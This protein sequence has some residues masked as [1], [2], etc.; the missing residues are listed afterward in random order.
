MLA[1]PSAERVPRHTSDAA[2]RAIQAQ[3]ARNIAY[4][5]ARPDEI[6]RRLSELDAEWDVERALATGSSC[7]SLLGLTLGQSGRRRWYML[8]ALV[9]GFYLQHTLQGWCPPLPVFR[10]LGFRTPAEIEH[11]RCALEAIQYRAA[12][13]DS[14]ALRAVPSA[15]RR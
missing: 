11:E 8:P 9:Q 4:F 1:T 15:T 3:T 2:N 13:A 7:L 5:K 14:N 6:P 10:W 12:G